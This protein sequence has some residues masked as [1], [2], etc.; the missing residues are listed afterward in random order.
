MTFPALVPLLKGF[1][2]TLDQWRVGREEDGWARSDKDHRE[3]IKVFCHNHQGEDYFIYD[4]MND[5][6]PLTVKPV[7]RFIDDFGGLMRIFGS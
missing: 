7:P 5:G 3:W 1:H 2:L 6:A 4:D